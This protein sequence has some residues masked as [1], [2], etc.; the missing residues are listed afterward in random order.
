MVEYDTYYPP[1]YGFIYRPVGDVS[2]SR[3]LSSKVFSRMLQTIKYDPEIIQHLVPWF[4]CTAETLW[5]ITSDARSFS[6]ISPKKELVQSSNN[7]AGDAARWRSYPM[8]N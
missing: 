8:K 7:T 6:I 5:S 1:I 2:I 3:E 4:Y